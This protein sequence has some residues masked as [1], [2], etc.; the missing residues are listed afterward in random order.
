M[1]ER[2]SF[3]KAARV[4]DLLFSLRHNHVHRRAGLAFPTGGV[5]ARDRHVH[6]RPGRQVGE[7][8]LG[9]IREFGRQFHAGGHFGHAETV[10]IGP[11]CRVAVGKDGAGT[12]A[13][14]SRR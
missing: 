1:K 2:P 3:P 14:K 8:G 5:S 11:L 10:A 13:F 12:A 6:V 9:F 4:L 7:H